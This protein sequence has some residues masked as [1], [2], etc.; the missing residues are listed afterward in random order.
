MYENRQTAKLLIAIVLALGTIFIV[1]KLG[2]RLWRGF[3]GSRAALVPSLFATLFLILLTLSF[4]NY[5]PHFLSNPPGRY[6]VEF[7]CGFLALAAVGRAWI[8]G[9]SHGAV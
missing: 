4:D 7:G 9:Q 8:G 3:R 6:V 2:A 1:R 5:M